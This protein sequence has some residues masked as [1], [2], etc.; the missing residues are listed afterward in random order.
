MIYIS[1]LVEGASISEIYLCKSKQN[2]VSKN[3]KNYMSLVLQD[4]TGLIDAKIWEPD[5]IT[6]NDFNVMDFI[7]ISGIVNSFNSNLQINIQSVTIADV[8]SYNEEDYSPT[9]EKDIDEMY[10]KLIELIK[11]VHNKYYNAL[12]TDFFIDNEK[13]IKRFKMSSAAKIVHHATIGGLLEHT[14]GVTEICSSLCDLHPMLNRDLLITA[15]I[16]HDIGK[17]K[18]FSTF[19]E[20][21]YTDDGNLL[22]HIYMG[23]EL[24]NE[25]ARR[26]EGF[27]KTLLN[28]LKHCILSHHGE[29]EYG[30]PKKPALIE[31]LALS[32]ADDM[33]AKIK[34]FESLIDEN[35][36][37]EW[38]DKADFFLG[39][40][41]RKTL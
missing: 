19:P 27:P 3:G 16:C 30:S 40:K 25:H 31:A 6:I 1:D 39:S 32:M 35:D 9:T 11:S 13:F 10:N 34:R 29:L 5:S 26:I 28:Q 12:L 15:A 2:M 21:D 8:N 17:V 20:N 23:T 22:G 38:S 18:E 4:K 41:Y 14:L 37:D 36:S 7:A 33:D 24:V